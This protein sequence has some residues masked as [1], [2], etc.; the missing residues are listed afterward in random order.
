MRACGQ[1]I[2][3]K[4][5]PPSGGNSPGEHVLAAHS[6]FKEA[7]AFQNENPPTGPAYFGREGGPC[8]LSQQ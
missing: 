2:L 3:N 5:E 1:Q 8:Q 6:V 4:T 7:L